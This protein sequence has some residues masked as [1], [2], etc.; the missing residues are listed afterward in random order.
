MSSENYILVSKSI[1]IFQKAD[2]EISENDFK[3]PEKVFSIPLSVN[4]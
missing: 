3:D 2:D 4:S 1:I